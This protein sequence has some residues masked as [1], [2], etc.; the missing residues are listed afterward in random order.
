WLYAE[1]D[2]W[3]HR[4]NHNAPCKDKNKFL[5]HGIP[6]II[7]AKP[8]G[9]NLLDFKL[10]VQSELFDEVE[11]IYAPPEHPVCDLVP[12]S[13]DQHAQYL[14]ASLGKP[15]V[16]SDSFW[17]VYQM[18]LAQFQAIEGD[19]D[20]TILLSQGVVEPEDEDVPLLPSLQDLPQNAGLVG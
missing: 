11:A 4:Q 14:Y 7:R 3:A 8:H 5:S 2:A 6:A 1:L 20:L 15:Q 13:F 10:P 17:N 19:D 12:P 18:L 16:S 9:F